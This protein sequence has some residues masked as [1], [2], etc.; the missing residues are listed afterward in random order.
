MEIG[1][2][3]KRVGEYSVGVIKRTRGDSFEVVLRDCG[4]YVEVA[5]KGVL[6]NDDDGLVIS[7]GFVLKDELKRG[8]EPL[9]RDEK[10]GVKS[11]TI[12]PFVLKLPKKL[13]ENVTLMHIKAEALAFRSLQDKIAKEAIDTFVASLDEAVAKA[14]DG[15]APDE[16]K[17]HWLDKI[18]DQTADH[19]VEDM[20]DLN[21]P[22]D[23]CAECEGTASSNEIKADVE[24]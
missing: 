20:K 17:L 24:E 18:S 8:A 6:I 11:L 13:P 5:P 14:N 19:Q 16:M 9:I 15:I 10:M 12:P 22:P 1:K 7:Q 21:A 4:D 3:L 2:G 23:N